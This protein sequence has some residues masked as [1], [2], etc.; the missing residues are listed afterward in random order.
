MKSKKIIV[1]LIAIGVVVVGF[2]G[3]SKLTGKSISQNVV[4]AKEEDKKDAK[5]SYKITDTE[6]DGYKNAS[7]DALEKYFNIC[8]EENDEMTFRASVLNEKTI[9][10][11][12]TNTLNSIN[13]AYDN[14]KM[15]K[16]EY[17]QELKACEESSKTYDFTIKKIQALGHGIVSAVWINQD[18]H[19]QCTFNENTKELDE[20]NIDRYS[21]MSNT[22][23]TLIDDELKNIGEKYIKDNELGKI[24]NP[25]CI[26]IK[27]TKINNQDGTSS[28]YCWDVFYQDKEDDSKKVM[29][30]ISNYSGEITGFQLNGYADYT[31]KQ[32]SKIE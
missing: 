20:I 23:V 4:Y 5:D 9:D 28:N 27:Q 22:E 29:I 14:G 25:N 10:E 11:L 15:S 8:D 18:K 13:E 17:E 16:E 32:F 2:V 7:K 30:S 6:K 26:L 1:V 19:Y 3:V 31:Y 21:D 12:K 24:E